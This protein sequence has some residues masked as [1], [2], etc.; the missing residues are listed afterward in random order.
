MNKAKGKTPKFEKKDFEVSPMCDLGQ[1]SPQC[2][3]VARKDGMAAVRSSKQGEETL[4]FDKDEWTAF[5]QG[6]K[7]GAFDM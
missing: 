6:V 2:V 3:L 7:S 4:V 5:I 1:P